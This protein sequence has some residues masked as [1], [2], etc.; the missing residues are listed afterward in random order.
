MHPIHFPL[1]QSTKRR[2]WH[3]PSSLSL[4]HATHIATHMPTKVRR[5]SVDDDPFTVALAPPEDETLEQRDVRLLLEQEAK[6]ISNSIDEQLSRE[7]KE[8]Q[9]GPRPVKVLLLG[10]LLPPARPCT[11]PFALRA[12]RIWCATYLAVRREL[13]LIRPGKSTTLK[14]FQLMYDPK[15]FRAERASW[16]AIVQL[17]VVRSIHVILDVITRAQ[18]RRPSD[19][20]PPDSPMVEDDLLALKMR[21]S[22]L[23]RIEEVLMQ[24]LIPSGPDKSDAARL[25]QLTNI[26]YSERPRNVNREVA[27]NSAMQWKDTFARLVT[28]DKA[29]F[30]SEKAVDWDDPSDPGFVLHSLAED[31]KDLWNHETVQTLLVRQ[32]LRLQEAAGFFLDCLDE[33]TALRYMPT[34]DHILRA[35]LKTLGVSEHRIKMTSGGMTGSISRDWRIYDVG[36]HRS[37]RAAWAPY[38][39]DM[40][41]IIF[42]APIS[43]FDQVLAE[44]PRVNRLADSVNL[45]TTIVS[46]KLL[47]NTNII[48]FLN[49]ID[50]MKSKLESGIKLV[51]Y[52]NSYGKRPNDLESA[53]SYLRKKFAGIQRENSPS[54]RVFY[55]HLTTVTDPK[56]TQYI[57]A[58]VKDMLMHQYLE[59]ASLI[60]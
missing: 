27:V 16:R 59:E 32:N 50:I 56:S 6:E 55:C 15:A 10:T 35:R 21:L 40:D 41:S 24:R 33:V 52:V 8:S 28:S 34:D 11:Q 36:G 60:P 13:K 5:R 44:E 37:L 58:N 47:A 18:N 39:D 51:D 38:F 22:P 20:S 25:A 53:S 7:K 12:E 1:G 48:L 54:H 29:S 4:D 42:L 45:W 3:V 23:I 26:P 43:A 2:P 31:M 30:D 14:N 19:G 9:R 17:N 49:K 46:N 57:L